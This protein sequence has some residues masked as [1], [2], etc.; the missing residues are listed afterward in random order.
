MRYHAVL[1]FAVTNNDMVPS[2]IRSGAINL[3]FCN[4]WRIWKVTYRRNDNAICRSQ[5]IFCI[6]EVVLYS[7][8]QN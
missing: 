2:H 6:T 8:F 7:N 4:D 5:N 3:S 1:M